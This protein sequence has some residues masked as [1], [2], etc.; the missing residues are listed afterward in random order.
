MIEMSHLSNL[1]TG[2]NRVEARL[3]SHG[4]V[5]VIFFFSEWDYIRGFI[6]CFN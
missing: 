3:G 6:E 5:I 2:K 1:L 4:R